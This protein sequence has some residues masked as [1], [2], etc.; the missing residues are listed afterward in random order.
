MKQQKWLSPFVCLLMLSAALMPGVGLAEAKPLELCGLITEVIDGGIILQDEQ[1]GEVL[2]NVDPETVL[3]GVLAETPLAEGMYVFAKSGGILTRS[4]PPQTHADRLGCYTLEGSVLQL[5]EEGVLLTG[6]K[7][8]GDVLVRLNGNMPHVF[9]GVPLKVYYDGSMA[10]SQP[11]KVT[12]RYIE[13][14]VVEGKV[15]KVT[16]DSLTL[17]SPG[18]ETVTVAI[19]ESTLLPASW[20]SGELKGRDA[21][22]YYSGAPDGAESA[23]TLAALEIVDPSS[24]LVPTTTME[25]A[26]TPTP[27]PTE[28]PTATPE[29]KEGQEEATQS[30]DASSPPTHTPAHTPTP[31]PSDSPTQPPESE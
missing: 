25:S 28:E 21:I 2:L 15:L 8:F 17:E 30:P 12:A 29:G 3:E 31:A 26:A 9:G 4:A 27:A 23:M 22:V 18:G 1:L 7:L 5:T 6:D 16:Q 19:G 20:F 10:M 14:P 11:G 24:I 13:V